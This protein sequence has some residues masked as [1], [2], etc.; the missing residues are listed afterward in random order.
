MDTE[1]RVCAFCEDRFVPRHPKQ[2][3]CSADC[4]YRNA[5]DLAAAKKRADRA[6]AA[7]Q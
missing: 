1:P 3:F 5:R 4:R 7:T 2:R 6:L